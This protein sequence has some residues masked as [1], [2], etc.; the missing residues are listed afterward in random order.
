VCDVAEE[1]GVENHANDG[2]VAA[3]RPLSH[4][5]MIAILI[6]ILQP[7]VRRRNAVARKSEARR[8]EIT[9]T[10]ETH[11]LLLWSLAANMK[12]SNKDMDGERPSINQTPSTRLC[13]YHPAGR[14]RPRNSAT[15]INDKA[16]P[17]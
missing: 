16:F 3:T 4:W 15:L 13:L 12:E 17:A 7:A 5:L 11:P 10:L 8:L 9:P 6:L 14:W 1:K 2:P